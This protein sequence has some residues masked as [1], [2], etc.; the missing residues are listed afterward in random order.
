M[1]DLPAMTDSAV[2]AAAGGS[3][4][5]LSLLA[6]AVLPRVRFMVAARLSPTPAQWDAVEEITQSTML[7]LTQGVD[8]LNCRTSAGL[9]AWL[10]GVVSHKVAD[11]LAQRGSTPPPPAQPAAGVLAADFQ[12]VASVWQTITGRVPTPSS[13]AQRAEQ[14]ESLMSELGRLKDDYREVITYAFFDQLTTARIAERMGRTRPAVSMLLIRAVKELRRR[15]MGEAE[16][17]LPACERTPR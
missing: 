14:I 3:S 7:A 12:S 5:A 8:R 13:I 1:P 10:S 4:E 2:V 16:P 17:N 11:Y 6:A 15:M 9:N